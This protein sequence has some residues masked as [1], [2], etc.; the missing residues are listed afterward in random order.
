[1]LSN[2]KRVVRTNYSNPPT[3]G[4]QIVATILG[5]SELKALWERELGEMRERI[6]RRIDATNADAVGTAGGSG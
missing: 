6:K 4:G 2:V 3:H 1:M 5:S